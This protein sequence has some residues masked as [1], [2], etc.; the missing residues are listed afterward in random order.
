MKLIDITGQTFGRLKVIKKAP[1]NCVWE[2]A[3]A[4]GAIR[5]YTG[6]QL[7]SGRAGQCNDCRL[8]AAVSRRPTDELDLWRADMALY[9][10]KVGYRRNR[11]PTGLLGN[12]Q[13]Q[14]RLRGPEDPQSSEHPALQWDVTL[15]EYIELVTAPCF[16][17]G[18]VPN[19]VPQG[20]WMRGTDLR[21]NGIDRVD[22]SRGYVMS[23]CVSC[24]GVCNRAKAARSQHDFIDLTCRRYEHLKARG[25]L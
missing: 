11:K 20:S 13:Y 21:R 2:C 15:E 18:Q 9:Q 22:N 17:C 19:Q 8:Q 24:C 25:L 1:Q 14:Q 16:Y 5:F 12:N 23:N 3:C 10:Q 6:T 7:R 4:C